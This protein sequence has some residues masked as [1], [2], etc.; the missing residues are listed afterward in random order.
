MTGRQQTTG[1]APWVPAGADVAG[2]RAALPDCRGCEL[3]AEA[4]HA[5]M[6]EGPDDASVMLLG[7]QPGAREDEAGR[8]FV[9]PAGRLMDEALERA[10]IDP[11]SVYRTNAVKHFR[12]ERRGSQRLHKSPSRWHVAACEPWLLGELEAVRPQLVVL[13]GATAGQAVFGPGFR[14]GTSRGSRLDW[15]Q[16]ADGAFRPAAALATTHPAAV[17]R[18]RERDAA[19]AGLVA[20]LETARGLVEG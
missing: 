11:A 20:D 4:E 19:M 1:A 6:G 15:P 16:T 9:G 7:E 17:L 13:L 18:S 5:V 8:P 12:F 14:V 10:G 3:Y 2:L